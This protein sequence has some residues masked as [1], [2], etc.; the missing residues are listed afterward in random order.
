VKEG[1]RFVVL[2]EEGVDIMVASGGINLHCDPLMR[3]EYSGSKK[4]SECNP[5]RDVD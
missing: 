3:L 2:H 1:A 4:R 5:R